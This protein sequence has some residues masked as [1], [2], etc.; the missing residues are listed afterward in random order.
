MSTTIEQVLK[1]CVEQV[2]NKEQVQQE[3]KYSSSMQTSY[4]TGPTGKQGL[5]RLF[6]DHDGGLDED[7]S[8]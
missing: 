4:S 6:C 5:V 1:C 7:D 2:V 3:N 8:T